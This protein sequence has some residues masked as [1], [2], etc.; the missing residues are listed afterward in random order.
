MLAEEAKAVGMQYKKLFLRK[1]SN[2]KKIFSRLQPLTHLQSKENYAVRSSI[3][4]SSVI[5]Q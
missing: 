4:R 1:I 5:F 2:Y 3:V